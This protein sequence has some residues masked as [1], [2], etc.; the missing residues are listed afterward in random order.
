MD[1]CDET[2]Q[3]TFMTFN[4]YCGLLYDLEQAN[5]PFSLC[6]SD[7]QLNREAFAQ[8][9]LFDTC[10]LASD[11]DAAKEAACQ[12]LS[13]L[14]TQCRQLNYAVDWRG[15]A[16]CRESSLK[17]FINF[18]C[19]S[20]SSAMGCTG[21]Q[22]Y[23]LSGPPCLVTCDN[24]RAVELCPLFNTETCVCPDGGVFLD[25]ECQ[26]YTACGCDDEDGNHHDV[27]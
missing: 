9:C 24:P 19:S 10:T 4:N 5:N 26:P 21:G 3:E 7:P 8:N 11:P 17:C 1:A 22:E 16:N 15:V 25:G 13:A 12:T 14:A 18:I 27:S 20:I 2:Q 6:Y 23:R